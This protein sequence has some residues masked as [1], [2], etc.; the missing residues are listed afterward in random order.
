MVQ[1][2]MAAPGMLVT[3]AALIGFLLCGLAASAQAQ[4]WSLESQLSQKVAYDSNLLL[5]PSNKVST[6][7]S[8]T[9]RRW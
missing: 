9:T 7:S 6:F 5:T 8:V 2:R 1:F 3:L 4:D